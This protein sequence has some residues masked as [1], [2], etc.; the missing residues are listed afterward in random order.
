MRLYYHPVSSNSRRVLLT[1]ILLDVKIDLAVIDLLKGEHK[2]ADYLL[3]NPNGKVPL[4]DDGDFRLW[5]SHAIIQYLADKRGDNSLYPGSVQARADVNRWLFWSA[6]HFT[7]AVGF[8]SRERVSK[9]MVGGVGAPDPAEVARGEALLSAA[10]EVLDS[11]LASRQWIAQERLTLADL[12]IASPLMHME[13]A[14]LPVGKYRHMQRWFAQVRALDA[15]QA[16]EPLRSEE[17]AKRLALN[18]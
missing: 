15:W 14:Q 8:I 9:K 10:A 16:S 5:E 13:A 17:L 6:Y 11:H 3:I 2:T 18:S 1:A 12:A 7:P 4:L